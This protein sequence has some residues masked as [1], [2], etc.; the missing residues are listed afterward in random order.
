MTGSANYFRMTRPDLAVAS[1]TCSQFNSCYGRK[2]VKAAEHLLQH[3][4]GSKHW[5]VGFARSGATLQDKWIIEVWVDAAHAVCPDTRRSRTGFFVTLNGNLLSHKCKLQPGVPSQSSTEAE[6]RAL[7]DALN[8]V[9]WI[10]MVL[11][12]IGIEVQ[13]P[14]RFQEDNKATIKLGEN[15][16]SSKRSKHIALRHHVIRYHNSKGTISLSYCETSEMIA[17]MLTKCLALPNFR[18]LRSA[19][20]TNV[21]VDRNDDDFNPDR[22][23]STRERL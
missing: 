3:A 18:R 5:G 23:S 7:A 9:V 17:D 20:M 21:H 2:H 6:Y 14:I 10:V 16:M 13:K 1:S 4:G 15:N 22:P 12:E 19:V 8:E 11:K